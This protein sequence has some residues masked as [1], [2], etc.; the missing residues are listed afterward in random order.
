MNQQRGFLD[1]QDRLA[2]ISS[3]GDPLENLN[4]TI[5]WEMFRGKPRRCF[6]KE[7]K[8]IGGRPPFDYVLMFKALVLRP[9]E[10]VP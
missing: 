2:L 4:R 3:Q 8:G 9:A 5:N 10:L 7:P 1:E 6:A